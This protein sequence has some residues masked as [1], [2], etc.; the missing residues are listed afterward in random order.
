MLVY[1][2]IDMLP[3]KQIIL[4][5]AEKRYNVTSDYHAIDSQTYTQP[6]SEHLLCDII[7]VILLYYILNNL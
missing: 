3:F 6:I 1:N 4:S 7:D 5:M 2:S